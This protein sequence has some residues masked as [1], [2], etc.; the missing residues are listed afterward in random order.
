MENVDRLEQFWHDF[1]KVL[2]ETV[3]LEGATVA[4]FL[5]MPVVIFNH[6][7]NVNVPENRTEVFL[8]T[9]VNHFSSIGLPFA[10]FRVSPLTRPSFV[11]LLERYGF[12]KES[13]QSIM[14]FEGKPSENRA[15]ANA[16]VN[17]I[18]EDEIDVFDRLMVESFEMPPEWKGALDKLIVDF[19]RKGARNYLAYTDGQPVGTTSLFSANKTGCILNVS[20]LKE[21][22]RRG[23]GTELTMQAVSDSFKEGNDLHT[24]QADK[25]GD[26][27]R[28]YQKI[29]F[30][31]DYTVSFFVKKLG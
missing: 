28:L 24:L 3:K 14:V 23:I 6:V 8:K 25:G 30:K 9:A 1:V 4:H 17:E 11:S 18:R 5:R 27:E 10:C 22:R 21:Y 26:A 19:I 16:M 7:T 13:E 31:T 20:T 2:P 12:E 29:G 15:N